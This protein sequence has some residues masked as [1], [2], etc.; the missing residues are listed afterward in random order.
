MCDKSGF[1]GKVL[2]SPK[3]SKKCP[4]WRG[5]FEFYKILSLIFAVT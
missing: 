4:R 2:V 1:S 3:M 5:F